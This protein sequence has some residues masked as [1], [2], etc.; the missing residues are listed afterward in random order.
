MALFSKLN[1]KINTQNIKY[2]TTVLD[3]ADVIFGDIL[4]ESRSILELDEETNIE[5][6]EEQ[7]QQEVQ[8][9]VV[10]SRV[11]ALNKQIENT[12]AKADKDVA[13]LQQ[14]AE[15]KVQS[16]ENRKDRLQ[17]K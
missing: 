8:D 17:G 1:Q 9:A 11:N 3:E 5:Q 12:K 13:R 10:D 2:E 7:A 6:A 15:R 14:N 4:D 16:L